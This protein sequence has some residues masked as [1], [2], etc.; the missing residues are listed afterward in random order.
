M[1]K[2]RP[3]NSRDLASYWVEYVIRHKGAAHMQ[4]PEVFQNIFQKNSID[5][6]AFLMVCIFI[7]FKVI[8]FVFKRLILKVCRSKSQQ[9]VDKIKKQQ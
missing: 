2:D 5:V 9:Q 8:K 3:M 6:I 1:Y 4:Y 7:I